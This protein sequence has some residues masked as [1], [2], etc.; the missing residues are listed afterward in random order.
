MVM[1][2]VGQS[3]ARALP[4]SAPSAASAT[5]AVLSMEVFIAARLAAMAHKVKR[6]DAAAALC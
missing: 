4:G 5:A 3:C 6:C 2:R 1:G